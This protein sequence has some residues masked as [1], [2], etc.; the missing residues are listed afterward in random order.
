MHAILLVAGKG[1]RMKELTLDKPKPMLSFKG[2]NLIEH[3]LD[4]LPKEATH[5]ILVIGYLGDVIKKHFGTSYKGIPITYVLQT[6][7]L[8]TGHSLWQAREHIKDKFM[9]LMGDDLYAKEDLASLARHEHAVLASNTGLKRSGGKIFLHRNG[10]IKEIIEDKDG[11][12][13]SPLIYTGACVLTPAIFSYPLV[14]IPGRVEYGLPQTLMQMTD[15]FP[16]HIVE[17]TF[18]KQITAPEDLE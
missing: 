5:I 7:L 11:S 12:L 13:A 9:V 8:G 4:S 17:A 18:W 3:K 15:K 1:T 16:I 14:Q 10:T 6:E 2:K